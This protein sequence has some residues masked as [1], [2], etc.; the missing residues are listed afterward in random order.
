MQDIHIHVRDHGGSMGLMEAL[1]FCT[2]PVA[3]VDHS[4]SMVAIS[5]EA[6]QTMMVYMQ[7]EGKADNSPEVHI[8]V[9]HKAH[10]LWQNMAECLLVV[11]TLDGIHWIGNDKVVVGMDDSCCC[12]V[13]NRNKE[14]DSPGD[15]VFELK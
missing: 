8:E 6:C 15:S 3:V 4:C 1:R 2:L 5:L 13:D 9:D 12:V 11:H 7:N 14:G 10:W